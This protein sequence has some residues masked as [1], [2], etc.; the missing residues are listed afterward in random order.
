MILIVAI[1]VSVAIALLRG[2]RLAGLAELRLRHAW[3]VLVAVA[4]QALGVFDVVGSSP[5]WGV[6]VGALLGVAA[7][8]VVLAVLWA[9]RR[10]PGVWLVGLGLLANLAVMVANGGWMP[11]TPEAL[12]SLGWPVMAAGTKLFRAENIVLPRAAT[13]LWWLSDVFAVRFPI[14]CVFS[15]GDV[16]VALGLFWLVNEAMVRHGR[17]AAWRAAET[18]G[19]DR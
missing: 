17:A 12:V 2:G 18:V 8:L 16:F 5:L 6:Q 1:L 15:I 10:L 14:L 13:R 19:G 9:N 4:L 7:T 3:L 11:V